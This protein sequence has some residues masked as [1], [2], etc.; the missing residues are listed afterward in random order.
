[1]GGAHSVDTVHTVESSTEWDGHVDA[2]Y[3][4]GSR[5]VVGTVHTVR[6]GHIVESEHMAGAA[7]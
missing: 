2:V 5:H 1:V 3:T 7:I 4:V 6:G